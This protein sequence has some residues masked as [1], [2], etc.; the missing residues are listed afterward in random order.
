[1]PATEVA[2]TT[3]KT[4]KK[5]V[6][7]TASNAKTAVAKKA[8]LARRAPEMA[9]AELTRVRGVA[10]RGLTRVTRAVKSTKA[11]IKKHPIASVGTLIGAGVLVGVA[12]QAMRHTPTM[13]EQMAEAL[14]LGASKA[15]KSL[16]SSA[17]DG[18]KK[19]G[20]SVRRALKY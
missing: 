14:S 17:R 2:K 10:K 13:G 15:T 1:M 11:V 19:A 9:S 16:A 4:M 7:K 20:S 5:A 12:A 8:A 3:P 18:I 6:K